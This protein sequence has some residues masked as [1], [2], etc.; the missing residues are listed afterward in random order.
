MKLL[1]I[2]DPK[3]EGI[4]KVVSK[5]ARKF[6][7]KVLYVPINRIRLE[8][9]DDIRVFYENED[10]GSYDG[11]LPM[12]TMENAEFFYLVTRML[13]KNVVYTPIPSDVILLPWNKPLLSYTLR[14]NGIK[15]RKV[16]AIAQ[17]VA[18]STIM[19]EIKFPV[20]ITTPSGRRVLVTKEE[21]LKDV[22][23]LFKAGNMITIEKPIKATSV[24]WSFVVGDE[25]IASYEKSEEKGRR[26]IRL[27]KEL[28]EISIKIR[29]ILKSDFCVLSFV[30]TKNET[31]LS[32]VSFSPDYKVFNEVTG[33]NTISLLLSYLAE[34]LYEEKKGM[35]NKFVDSVKGILGWLLN[36]VSNL[37]SVKQRV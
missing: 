15:I 14:K 36:E 34:K 26:A 29:E 17:N 16:F 35:L 27:D 11:V 1:I 6:F 12:P 30:K 33:I 9:S 19:N 3:E 2:G 28:E 23:N 7:T 13:E 18:A 4:G 24:V 8:V 25:V 31:V 37:R 5:E 22:L 32:N 20:F 10:L 21:V